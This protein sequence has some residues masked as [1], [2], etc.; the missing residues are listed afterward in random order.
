M[1]KRKSASRGERRVS[2]PPHAQI[3]CDIGPETAKATQLLAETLD[4]IK[5]FQLDG[6]FEMMTEAMKVG[7]SDSESAEVIRA[8][9][10]RLQSGGSLDIVTLQRWIQVHQGDS[11]SV[12]DC[13]FADPPEGINILE[14]LSR[15]GS[16]KLVFLAN[17]QI[18]QREVVLKRFRGADA[19]NRILQR[20]TQTHPLSMAHPNIIET[21]LLQNSKGEYFLVERRLPLVLSDEWTSN[22]LQEAA[23]LLRDIASALAFLCAQDLAHGD[24]KPDNIGFEGGRYI[25]LDFGIC[26]PRGAFEADVTPTGS[27]RTRAPELL[28]EEGKHSDLSDIWALGATVFNTLAGRFPLFDAN[29][30]P[31]RASDAEEREKFEEVLRNRVQNEWDERIDFSSVPEPL[32]PLLGRMLER[33]PQSRI[34]AR[35]LLRQAETELSAVLRF[36]EESTYI[37]P[38]REI[39]QL[40]RFLPNKSILAVLP[41]AQRRELR[42]RVER[43]STS[44][45][46]TSHE[47]SELKSIESR[48]P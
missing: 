44:K 39:E 42:S 11:S 23:N 22:G 17:W 4:G 20:E 16:Q 15:A 29:E 25:L 35:E 33:K 47:L 12:R 45:G 34:E 43:L 6:L 46:L 41:E 27:L 26:R 24:I 5:I 14:V 2:L 13:I 3:L 37:S 21:H 32:R 7:W 36:S 38:S 28:M 40:K 18:A 30:K 8:V 31:P 1:A 48:L 19:A 10:D 9:T